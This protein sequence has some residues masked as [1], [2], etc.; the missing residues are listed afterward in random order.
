MYP[1]NCTSLLCLILCLSQAKNKGLFL[2]RL[3]FISPCPALSDATIFHFFTIRLLPIQIESTICILHSST[4]AFLPPP[5]CLAIIAPCLTT[6]CN[7]KWY[8]QCPIPWAVPFKKTFRIIYGLDQCKEIQWYRQF[9]LKYPHFLLVISSHLTYKA[10]S[11]Q[12]F[13]QRSNITLT[14]NVPA[15]LNHITVAWLPALKQ[16]HSKSIVVEGDQY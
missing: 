14:E 10:P 6:C 9:Y 15:S 16:T 5:S 1:W 4:V 3:H 8:Q 12:L 11:P 7:S 2:P 13:L